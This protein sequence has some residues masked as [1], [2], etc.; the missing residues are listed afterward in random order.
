TVAGGGVGFHNVVV[1]ASADQEAGTSSGAKVVALANLD[2]QAA[3]LI[4]GHNGVAALAFAH[5]PGGTNATAS[6]NVALNAQQVQLGVSHNTF[7]IHGSGG[8]VATASASYGVL[9]AAA[10]VY[11][12]SDD[13]N[14]HGAHALANVN[15]NAPHNNIIIGGG[16]D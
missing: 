14:G 1:L 7:H 15:I 5:D 16:V 8:T 11:S 4:N 3:G 10:A 13:S 2:I 9:A 12:G 6:A